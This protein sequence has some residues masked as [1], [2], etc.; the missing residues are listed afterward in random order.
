MIAAVAPSVWSDRPTGTRQRARHVGDGAQ[1]HLGRRGRIG[2]V[3]AQQDDAHRPAVPGGRHRRIDLGL[4]GH[5]GGHDQDLAGGRDAGDQRE[6]DQLERGDLVHRS[7]RSRSRKS[8]AAAS[9]G[10][11]NGTTPQRSGSANRSS[12]HSYG[13]AASR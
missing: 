8:T 13:V 9:N 4:G 7:G 12:C 11:E 5:A 6:V 10:V 3:A 1:V 2:A